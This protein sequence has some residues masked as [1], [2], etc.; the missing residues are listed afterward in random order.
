MSNTLKENELHP[1]FKS[2]WKRFSLERFWILKHIHAL[3]YND[4]K[5]WTK[6]RARA[7][8]LLSVEPLLGQFLHHRELQC[9]NIAKWECNQRVMRMLLKSVSRQLYNIRKWV[10]NCIANR[11][12]V[13]LLYSRSNRLEIDS[14]FS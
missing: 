9:S 10:S 7:A 3:N 5:R 1:T 14:R 11:D 2:F 6:R 12:L 13:G 4:V 8:A